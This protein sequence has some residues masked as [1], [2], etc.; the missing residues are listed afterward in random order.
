MK[1]K[2]QFSTKKVG[3]FATAKLLA[4]MLCIVAA[5]AIIGCKEDEPD[6]PPPPP[7]QEQP[8]GNVT[9]GGKTIPVYKAAG[10]SDADAATTIEY[11]KTAISD[12]NFATGAPAYFADNVTRIEIGGTEVT[13]NAGILRIQ[14]NLAASLIRGGLNAIYNSSLGR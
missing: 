3:S 10:V 6:P 13:L 14:A 4:I 9:I 5:L 1:T 8:I 2:K 7:P 11:L 12:S